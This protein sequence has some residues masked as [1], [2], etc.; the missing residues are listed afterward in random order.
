M[1]KLI[2]ITPLAINR[3]KHIL[4]ITNSNAIK[5]RIKGGGCNGFNYELKPTNNLPDKLDEHVN[6]DNVDIHICGSSLLHI[7]GTNIDYKEDIMG[8]LFTFDNP[9]ANSQ[10][11]CGTSFGI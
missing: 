4:K 1:N 11:G 10:C 5:F 7:I 8:S 2:T 3:L 9:N 6:I